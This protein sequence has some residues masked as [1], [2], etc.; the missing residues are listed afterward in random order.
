[1]Y[2]LS[3]NINLSKLTP[4]VPECL[5]GRVFSLEE[6][7]IPRVCFSNSIYNCLLGLQIKADDFKDCDII[8]YY[9]YKPKMYLGAIW[10]NKDIVDMAYVFDAH[11]TNEHWYLDEVNVVL[12]G[13]VLIYPTCIGKINYKP[14][15]PEEWLNLKRPVVNNKARLTTYMYDHVF[16]PYESI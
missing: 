14:L 16:I 11:I 15:L 6:N 10:Y 8:E 4:K 7:T 12:V 3:N 5:V 9:V 13:K 1:M 2:H